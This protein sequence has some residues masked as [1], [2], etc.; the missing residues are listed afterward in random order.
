VDRENCGV[1]AEFDSL[2]LLFFGH[3]VDLAFPVGSEGLEM[4]FVYTPTSI[5]WKDL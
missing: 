4:R 3:G 5:A 2:Y 1:M